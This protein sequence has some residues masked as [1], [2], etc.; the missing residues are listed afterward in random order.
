M[1]STFFTKLNKFKI[2]SQTEK[3]SQ[4]LHIFNTQYCYYL[5][6]YTG[7]PASGNLLIKRLI[8]TMSKLSHGQIT[9]KLI[10]IV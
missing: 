5:W 4:Y 8:P 9:T 1:L 10:N 7:Q 6:Q 2:Y 3:V